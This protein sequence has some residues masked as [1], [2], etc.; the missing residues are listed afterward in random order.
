[1]HSHPLRCVNGPSR[2][3]FLKQVA[4]TSAAVSAPYFAPSRVFGA[5][6]PSNRISVGVI[7]LGTRGTPDMKIFMRNQDVQIVAICDV[8]RASKGYRDEKAVMGREPALKIVNDF[9]G[10]QRRSGQ[11][12]GVDACTDFR[13]VIDRNDIDVVAVVAPDHWHAAMT[14][15]A[16]EAGKDIFCQKPL[17]LTIRQG[18]EMIRAVRKHG[19]ILQTGSQW[20]SNAAV[21]FTCELV[22]NER[23]GK[24]QTIRTW[25]PPNNKTDPG[26]GWKPMPVPEGFDYDMWL[27]PAPM[28]PYHKD[29]CI[30]KFRFNL[31]YSGGQITN[32][33]AHDI[34]IAQ[35]G[36]G[37]SLTGPVEVEGL[38]AEWP[39]QGSLFT[40]ALRSKFRARYANGV[41]LICET[42]SPGFGTR[43]EGTDGWVEFSRGGVDTHPKSLLSTRF[44]PN[45]VRLPAAN[46]SR[47]V[48]AP[49]DFYADHVRNFLDCVK[50]REEPLEPVEVGHRT[51][52]ICHLGN[53]AIQLMR[54][55]AWDPAAERFVND[56]EANAM[57]GR[58][59]RNDW[60]T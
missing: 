37:S 59:A 2:R 16:A 18:Q 35:W 42:A 4:A 31:D 5:T 10:A 24:L 17:T 49:G 58:L 48:D 29:R 25:L 15:M 50:S 23:I 60:L 33:G 6:A 44:G 28:A 27:G 7:G 19:R 3:S 20:R 11:F 12:H 9:Y 13:Q 34:D 1:M 43:F 30:Y 32:F 14:I 39:P 54:K 22:R 41:E 21:R 57:L 40:T 55:L 38:S 47:N 36:N 8:N 53:I 45:D 56:A 52:S 46:P 26:P 51:A